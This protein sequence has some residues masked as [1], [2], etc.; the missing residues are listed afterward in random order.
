MCGLIIYL[1]FVEC[2][3]IAKN[4]VAATSRNRLNPFLTDLC[5]HN[6]AT[7]DSILKVTFV[8]TKQVVSRIELGRLVL[9]N[10]SIRNHPTDRPIRHMV[11]GNSARI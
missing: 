1:G 2:T 11:V 5:H 8:T 7:C 4:E 10:V 9:Y 6:R 3:A